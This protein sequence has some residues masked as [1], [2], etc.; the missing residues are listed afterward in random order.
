MTKT[1]PTRAELDPERTWDALSIFATF[2]AWQDAIDTLEHDLVRLESFKGHLG[3]SAAILLEALDFVWDVRARAERIFTFAGLFSSV[4]TQDQEARARS[5]RASSL[6]ARVGAEAAF[7]EPEI[8]G[9]GKQKLEAF[10]ARESGLG[11][12]A[13]LFDSIERQRAHTRSAEVEQLLGALE[14]PFRTASAT[15]GTL[16]NAE[17]KFE[18]AKDSRGLSFEV[19]QGSIGSLTTD[20]DRDL[21]RSAYMSYADAHL[22]FKNTM[23]NALAAGVKQDVFRA[24]ARGYGSSLEAAMEGSFIPTGVFHTLIGTFKRFIP[25]WHRYWALRKRALGLAD[26]AEYDIKAPLT[27]TALARTTAPDGQLAL[28]HVSYEQAVDLICEGMKPLGEE[29]GQIMR[30]GLLEDRWVDVYPNRGKRMGA[31]STGA[32]GTHPFILMSYQDTLLSLSTL[33]HEIGHSM[34]SYHTWRAQ[35]PVYAEYTL[36]VAEVAS[37]F[38]QALVRDHLLQT[39]PDR[40]FQISVLEEAMSNFHRYFFVMPTLA[41]FELEIHTLV[42]NGE[43]LTADALTN[44]CADLFTEAYGPAVSVDRDRV[45]ITWA[46][47]SSHLYSNF[48]VHQ[49]ATGIS[50]AHALAQGVLAGKPDAATNY[51]KFLSAGSSVYPLDA[52]KLAGVDLSS[53]EAV[54]ETFKVLEGYVDRLE[55]LLG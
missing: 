6:Y 21:R 18:A 39:N 38:N 26:F 35:P 1:L 13:H 52:L 11:V 54:E 42:E 8:L 34:H 32:Q 23:A 43:T 25:V 50:G 2:Q 7:I 28:P 19:A 53:P 17:L 22:A 15:H 44:L 36:F 27:N 9:L 31:F 10:M 45:G 14:D 46:E 37:N 49:Y 48:Y 3:D 20:P 41:R 55:K 51:L 16:T 40:D 5:G 29:Y 12:Y 24:R 4:D 33:A 47:F 30:K